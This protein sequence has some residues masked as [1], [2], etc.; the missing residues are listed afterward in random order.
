[1]SNNQTKSSSPRRQTYGFSNFMNTIHNVCNKKP[2]NEQNSVKEITKNMDKDNANVTKIMMEEGIQAGVK[3]M[4]TEKDA[5]GKER[6][7]SYS[8]MRSRYG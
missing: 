3:A 4:F 1:M 6:Q 7:L 2:T 5:N 8:E